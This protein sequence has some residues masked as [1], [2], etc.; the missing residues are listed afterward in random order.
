M[1]AALSPKKMKHGA[2][3]GSPTLSISPRPDLT[4]CSVE[5][6]QVESQAAALFI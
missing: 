2:Q 5:A 1:G 4:E 3:L 6:R